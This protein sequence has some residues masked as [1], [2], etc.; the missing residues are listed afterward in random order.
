MLAMKISLSIEVNEKKHVQLSDNKD[1][2][3]N[4]KYAG[5]EKKK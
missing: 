4:R 2:G 5:Q 1:H 3:Y